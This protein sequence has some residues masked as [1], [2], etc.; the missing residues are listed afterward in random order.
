MKKILSILL[1]LPLL[2][3]N[4]KKEDPILFEMVYAENFTIPAGINPFD[5]HYFRIKNI[6]IGTYLSSRN[7]TTDMLNSIN[8]R[9]ANF[10]NVFAGTA[11][12][13][14]IRDVSVRIYTD[15]E[16][17]FKEL[18]YYDLVPENTGDNLGIIPSLVDTKDFLNDTH[19][20]III[21][22]NFRQPPVQNIETRL[23]FSLG[24]K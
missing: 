15:D 1:I 14:L 13:D 22:L 5:T 6:P 24:V 3:S 12:Y 4:C 19:F 23:R 8:P 21:R 7:L 16:N 11:S 2:F 20:N 18:F 9:A 17:N 10:V